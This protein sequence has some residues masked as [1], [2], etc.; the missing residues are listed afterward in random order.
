ML[1][2]LSIP[3]GCKADGSSGFRM[4]TNS[5]LDLHHQAVTQPAVQKQEPSHVANSF[6]NCYSQQ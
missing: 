1:S 6:F 2:K 4:L 5:Y 3:A